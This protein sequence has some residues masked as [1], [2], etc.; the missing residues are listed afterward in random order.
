MKNESEFKSQ[1]INEVC[2]QFNN[3][4]IQVIEAGKS[5][6][7]NQQYVSYSISFDDFITKRRYSEFEDLQKYFMTMYPEMIIPVIP[8]K[9]NVRNL[10]MKKAKVEP[11]MIGKSKRMLQ[12]FLKRVLEHPKLS[13]D[14]LFHRFLKDELTF[15]EICISEGYKRQKPL[16]FKQNKLRENLQKWDDHARSNELQK[17]NTEQL[18]K[19]HKKMVKV[20]QDKEQNYCELGVKLN[21][22][23]LE[24]ADSGLLESLGQRIDDCEI[25]QSDL[26][27]MM[28]EKVVEKL[29]E[30][31]QLTMMVERA[32][33]SRAWR[34]YEK[35][36][37]K[38]KL[39]SQENELHSLENSSR[40]L[41]KKRKML[42][43]GSSLSKLMD[44]DNE[45]SK[46]HQMSQLN[47]S[48]AELR[49]EAD[50]REKEMNLKTEEL[51][52]ELK[53]FKGEMDNEWKS[54][55]KEYAMGWLN[56]HKD[57]LKSWC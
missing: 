45:M 21:G 32:L 33:K 22:W 6:S 52:L 18:W 46:Q 29:Q 7:T 44:G 14:H 49:S 13:Q 38:E 23:S 47:D 35:E 31:C 8:E 5:P 43:L 55:M 26:T 15:K 11:E 42:C 17:E 25:H 19:T 9:H 16:I 3:T 20:L 53:R 57:S 34:Q 48:M 51:E 12:V 4:E 56:Y 54:F 30:K 2:C 37:L 50:E 24:D 41:P 1:S 10:I 27:R 39:A 36:M 40:A 28:K